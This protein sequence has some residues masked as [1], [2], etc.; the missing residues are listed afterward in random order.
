M[1]FHRGASAKLRAQFRQ[2]QRESAEAGVESRSGCLWLPLLLLA[3]AFPPVALIVLPW[4]SISDAKR[5]ALIRTRLAQKRRC[6][7][8]PVQ[9]AACRNWM[10]IA[11]KFCLNCYYLHWRCENCHVWVAE[12]QAFCAGCEK[13]LWHAEALNQKTLLETE[14]LKVVKANHD[15]PVRCVGCDR[16][17]GGLDHF[18][19]YCGAANEEYGHPYFTDRRSDFPDGSDRIPGPFSFRN[20]GR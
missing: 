8:H 17:I 3:A 12:G 14:A 1:S 2:D 11:D 19:T 4:L 20:W 15:K 10:P 5:T 16:Y 13:K 6:G 9:C 18:C 7:P